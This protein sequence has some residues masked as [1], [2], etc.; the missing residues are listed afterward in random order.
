MKMA[1]AALIFVTF[2]ARL[3]LVSNNLLTFAPENKKHYNYGRR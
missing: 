3:Q 2:S 1:A